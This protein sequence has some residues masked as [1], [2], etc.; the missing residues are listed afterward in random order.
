MIVPVDLGSCPLCKSKCFLQ[1]YE[2]YYVACTR[3]VCPYL[4]PD[5]RSAEAAI[6]LHNLLSA[7][8]D[9]VDELSALL[10]QAN[11]KNSNT[12]DTD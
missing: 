10:A 11:K 2:V 6:E 9:Q 5:L 4:G 12:N 3:A 1:D 8:S 7:K